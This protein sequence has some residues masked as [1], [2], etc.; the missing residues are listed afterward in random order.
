MNLTDKQI[1]QIESY[2]SGHMNPDELIKFKELLESN[3]SVQEYLKIN[4]EIQRQFDSEDWVFEKKIEGGEMEDIEKEIKSKS[5]KLSKS[6]IESVSLSHRKNH[7]SSNRYFYA[8][9]AA[10]IVVFFTITFLIK[11]NLDSSEL[12]VFYSDYSGL[13]TFVNRGSGKVLE[14]AEE[15]FKNG[16]YAEA[17]QIFSENSSQSDNKATIYIYQGLSQI[18]LNQFSN[19]E[20]TF[21]SLINS[22][23]I[24]SQKGYWYTALLYLKQERIDEVKEVLNIIISNSYYNHE[25]A[26]D[27]LNEI[28]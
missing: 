22:N 12:Y 27:L 1:E 9:I 21:N 17:L 18:E 13:P 5:F 25:K 7:K 20:A 6:L 23:L 19:A 16:R 10:V 2:L 4:Y 28:E 14:N 15:L 11:S 8:G 24:D 26:Q 3:T